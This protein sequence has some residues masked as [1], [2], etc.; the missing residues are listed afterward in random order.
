M[1]AALAAH[2][3]SA[4]VTVSGYEGCELLVARLLVEAG[5]EVPYV[6]TACPRTEWSEADR[7]WLDARGVHVQYR[8]SLEQDVAAMEEVQARPRHRHHAAGA[9]GKELGIP[10][11]YF[12][13]MVSARPLFGP[14]GAALAWPPSSPRRPRAA[15]AS[16][17]WSASSRASAPRTAPATASPASPNDPP[18]FRDRQRKQRVARAKAEEAVGT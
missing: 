8:A 5:A 11:L 10:S 16:A 18:G 14:A 13:N 4:R 1:Q 3:I 6:G 2:P 7:A 9:E 17:A 12:T 15:S